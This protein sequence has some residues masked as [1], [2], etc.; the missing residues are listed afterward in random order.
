MYAK[1]GSQAGLN[2]IPYGFAAAASLDGGRLTKTLQ[3]ANVYRL[4][5][6]RLMF[7]AHGC[8]RALSTGSP[9]ARWRP[10]K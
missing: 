10:R 3:E 4:E 8:N 5:S 2:R 1:I 9:D 6:F 7:L